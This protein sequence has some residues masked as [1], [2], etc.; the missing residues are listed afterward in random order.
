MISNLF[1]SERSASTRPRPMSHENWRPSLHHRILYR[2]IVKMNYV[3]VK[4]STIR[5]DDVVSIHGTTYTVVSSDAHSTMNGLWSLTLTDV[6]GASTVMTVAKNILVSKTKTFKTWERDIK[7][8][9]HID[10]TMCKCEKC[11]YNV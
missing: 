8:R 9:V 3:D 4:V 11:V 5:P 6:K 2:V 1:R 10:D 7:E